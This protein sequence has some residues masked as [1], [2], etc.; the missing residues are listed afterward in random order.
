MT[1]AVW[2]PPKDSYKLGHTPKGLYC[3]KR[4]GSMSPNPLLRTPSQKA[5]PDMSVPRGKSWPPTVSQQFLTRTCLRPNSLLKCLPNFLSALREGNS[6]LKITPV[7]RVIVWNR[8]A[9]RAV[10][11]SKNPFLPLK[12]T[13]RHLLSTLLR[14]FCKFGC[15]F[16]AYSRKLP[17]YSGA[18]LLTVDNFSFLLM[19]GAFLLTVL[20]S[21]LTV[22]AFFCLQ[23]ESASNRGLKGL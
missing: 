23:W 15:G 7:A 14:T 1:E 18:F 20:A 2:V 17:A 21:L 8:L 11:A 19:V 13:T 3:L 4:R 5:L 9:A 16:F 6:S 12:P 22:G 10:W